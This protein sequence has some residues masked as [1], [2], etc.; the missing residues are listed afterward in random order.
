MITRIK[1][2]YETAYQSGAKAL[3]IPEPVQRRLT[4]TKGTPAG[5]PF[6]EGAVF[7]FESGVQG[8]NLKDGS[9]RS[10]DFIYRL[11]GEE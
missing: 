8:K 10:M 3:L 11:L 1:L 5:A 2:G 7:W 4:A 9:V 6:E